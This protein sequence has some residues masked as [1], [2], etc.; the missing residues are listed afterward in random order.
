MGT[1]LM[2]PGKKKK[3]LGRSR[4]TD[5]LSFSLRTFELII[6]LLDVLENDF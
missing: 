4:L 2:H 3:R 6:C 5:V 1:H